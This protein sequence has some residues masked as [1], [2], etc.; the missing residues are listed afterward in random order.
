[1][2]EKQ[3]IPMLNDNE[4]PLFTWPSERPQLIGGKCKTCGEVIFPKQPQCP[5]CYTE[6][7][8]ELLLSTRGKIYSSTVSYIPPPMYEGPVPYAVGY[9]ELPERVLIATPFSGTGTVPP[10]IG[11]EVELVIEELGEDDEGNMLMQH[12]FKPVQK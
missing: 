11:T 7:V 4:S 9:V 8:E 5:K 3:T 1:M 10:P 6:T 12:K 2:T